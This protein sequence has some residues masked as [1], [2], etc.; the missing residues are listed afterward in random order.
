M[1]DS[2]MKVQMI[3]GFNVQGITRVVLMQL[4]EKWNDT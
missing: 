2:F 4:S 3:R 1:L